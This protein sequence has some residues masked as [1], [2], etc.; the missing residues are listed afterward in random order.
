M[1]NFDLSSIVDETSV[2]FILKLFPF[3]VGIVTFITYSLIYITSLIHRFAVVYGD[4]LFVFQRDLDFTID[5]DFH[6][7][8]SQLVNT[9]HYKMR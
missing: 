9:M 7:E 5:L 2:Y 4:F 8:L 6:G 3:N 1:I